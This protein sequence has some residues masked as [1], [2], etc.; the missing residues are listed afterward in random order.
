MRKRLQ[1]SDSFYESLSDITMATLGIF[2]IFFVI[3]VIFVNKDTIEKSVENEK[4]K[5]ETA[6]VSS[7]L[8]KA[9]L[10]D[11]KKIKEKKDNN[12]KKIKELESKI[13]T[14]NQSLSSV[15]TNI[16][17]ISKIIKSQF[18]MPDIFN[19]NSVLDIKKISQDFD[20]K[21]LKPNY[22]MHKSKEEN[23][24]GNTVNILKHKVKRRP[25]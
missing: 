21:D 2:V 14:A 20:P 25:C 6:E 16:N 3:N 5:K 23:L 8:E 11:L 4:F 17:R 9:K 12:D 19:T 24:V 22:R 10:D 13:T 18:S 7:T 15:N 1:S